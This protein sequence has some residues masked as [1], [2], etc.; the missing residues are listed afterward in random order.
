[1]N[2]KLHRHIKLHFFVIF[3]FFFSLLFSCSS[4]KNLKE[5]ELLLQKNSISIKSKNKIKNLGDI[6]DNLYKLTIQ[7][8]NTTYNILGFI[9]V[10]YKL[11]HYNYKLKRKG[12]LPDS[13]M[14]KSM[15]K[16]ILFDSVPITRSVLNMRNYLFNLGYFNVN[17]VSNY[18]IKHK[19]VVVEYKIY[20]DNNY[21]INKIKYNIDDSDIAHIVLPAAEQTNFKKDA[22]YTISL[23][24]D[25]RSRLT[26]L[27]RNN[28]YYHF[29][30]ENIT[31]KLDTFINYAIKN[32][33]SSLDSNTTIA[34]NIKIKK[35]KPQLDIEIFIRRTDDSTAYKKYKI[36]KIEVFPDY[37]DIVDFNDTNLIKRNLDSI[38][39]VYKS[40]YLHSKVVS[41]HIFIRP[42]KEY[43]QSDYDKTTAKLNELGIFQFLSIKY[44]TDP[45]DKYLLNCNIIMNRSKKHDIST[46]VEV[47]SGSTYALGSSAGI[48]F[49][50]RNFAKGANLLTI[51]LNGGIELLYSENI[52]KTI[53]QHFSLL[54][55]Y[56]GINA[57]LDLP[58]FVSPVG[59]SLFD[60]TNLPHTVLSGGT[61]VMDRVNYFTLINTS[62]N[63]GYNWHKTK[64]ITWAFSPVIVN[65]IRVP[66]ESAS[67]KA[68]LDSI[69][70]LKNSYK[71]NFIEGE[72][73][74]FTYSDNEKKRGRNYSFLKIGIEESGGILGVLNQLGAAL[75]D[76]YKIK[77]AQYS[78][79]DID[80]RHYFNI[81]HSVFAVRFF[82]GVGIPYGQSNTLPYI[83]Q[84]YVGGPY[85]LRGWQLRSLGPG[86]YADV[87]TTNNSS[88]IDRTGD[89]KL[90]MNGEYRFPILPITSSVKMNGAFFTDA[91]NIWLAKKDPN[92]P[93]GEIELSSFGQDIGIDV[94]AGLRFDVA[95]FL[96]FRFDV[97]MPVKK[98]SVFTNNGWVFDQIELNNRTWRTNNIVFG[99]SIGYPF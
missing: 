35:D 57:S 65:I 95:S 97:A 16:P 1:M 30:Q 29:T 86:H 6:K 41:D 53:F 50:D 48:N 21:A 68:R 34:E 71:Q 55:S 28:G 23:L 40:N 39:F 42:N 66:E 98:P 70:F 87:L 88:L 24:E 64:T 46:N 36:N 58:K 82:S 37:S 18:E 54:T 3:C 77:Y 25:E 96:N 43:S 9:P 38:Q 62:G 5:N 99:F 94:G 49:R 19:K 27:L 15:E 31:F 67:F 74:T 59:I 47:S 93:G 89:I 79:I 80:A 7:K 91:G 73:I 84:Y 60:P 10:K 33:N 4:T 52:G 17:V 61:N 78:K 44:Y 26:A 12:I 92:F 90:E 69:P 85:S 45:F 72:N 22:D 83:K 11:G 32:V 81:K 56:Y 63:F 8:P 20:T 2:N 76:L 51:S 14:R 75:N 13:M